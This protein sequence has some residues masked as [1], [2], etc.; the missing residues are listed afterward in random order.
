MPVGSHYA[1]VHSEISCDQEVSE[2]C[3][4]EFSAYVTSVSINEKGRLYSRVPG[5]RTFWEN[6]GWHLEDGYA[7]C[8]A[9]QK[10][11]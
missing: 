5:R 9:C 4:G 11:E 8:P 2:D 6:Q 10:E 7:T 1:D 3:L